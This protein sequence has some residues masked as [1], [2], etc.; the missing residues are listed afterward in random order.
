[1]GPSSLPRDLD[2]RIVDLCHCRIFLFVRLYVLALLLFTPLSGWPSL[3]VQPILGGT[4][5]HFGDAVQPIHGLRAS[6]AV[7]KPGRH[8]RVSFL[9][10]TMK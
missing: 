6:L 10:E 8:H 2:L 9:P 7:A 5:V 3:V 4:Q 1:M